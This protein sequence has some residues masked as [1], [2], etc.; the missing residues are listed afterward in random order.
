[1]PNDIGAASRTSPR[2]TAPRSEIASSIA[3]PSA[4]SSDARSWASWPLSVSD[5]LRELRWNSG[6]ASLCSSREIALDTVAFDSASSSAAAEKLPSSATFAKIAQA[7]KSG[8]RAMQAPQMVGRGSGV[9][10]G[11]DRFRSS[12]FICRPASLD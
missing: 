1:M 10:T 5:N 9:K 7:S 11:N 12:P 6:A 2:G 8:R 4:S 3:S